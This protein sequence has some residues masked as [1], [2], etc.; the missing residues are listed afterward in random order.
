MLSQT[1]RLKLFAFACN[2]G[3]LGIVGVNY[4]AH[5]GTITRSRDTSWNTPLHIIGHA[6]LALLLTSWLR[7]LCQPYLRLP[8]GWQERIGARD[9]VL[10]S[11]S[12]RAMPPRAFESRGHVLLGFDHNCRWLG[13]PV[14][15]HNR[16]FFVL[17][18]FWG[19]AMCTFAGTLSAFDLAALKS[20]AN[21]G[22]GDGGFSLL[23]AVSLS[24]SP[25]RLMLAVAEIGSVPLPA[26]L[27]FL[28]TLTGGLLLCLFV[29]NLRDVLRN[30]TA[31]EGA[32]ATWD[33]G[34]AANLRQWLGESPALWLVPVANI[35]VDG[36][37][38]PTGKLD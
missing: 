9:V 34:R 35:P 8:A 21:G 25:L 3:L 16:K 20:G 17:T 22:E 29:T 27:I 37:V 12:G 24:A 31:F 30:V 6:I 14:A 13:V 7:T 33:L 19:A 15:L 10:S 36:I 26:L 32:R 23:R 28:D 11:K 4:V 38:W 2:T 18:M 1:R 5:V